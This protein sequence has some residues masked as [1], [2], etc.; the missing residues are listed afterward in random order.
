MA[1]RPWTSC[2]RERDQLLPRAR[3]VRVAILFVVYVFNFIDR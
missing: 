2:R 1:A 3:Q